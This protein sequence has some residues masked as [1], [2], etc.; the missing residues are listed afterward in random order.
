[1]KNKV[2]FISK[3]MIMLLSGSLLTFCS[4]GRIAIASVSENKTVVD[5]WEESYRNLPEKGL[6]EKTFDE[7]DIE[8]KNLLKND[9]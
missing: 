6:E 8:E 4:G 2:H 1:M 3:I 9:M 7:K 5:L